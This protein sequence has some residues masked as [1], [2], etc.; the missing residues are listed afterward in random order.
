MSDTKHLPKK[1]YPLCNSGEKK[2]IPIARAAMTALLL[3]LLIAFPVLSAA[4]AAPV[5]SSTPKQLV[6][7]LQDKY[8]LV[9]SLQFDFSQVTRSGGRERQG[10]GYAVFL[11]PKQTGNGQDDDLPAAV[12]RW[13][14]TVPERQVILNDGKELSIYNVRERQL[15]ITPARQLN[16]DITYAFF[17]GTRNILDDFKAAAPDPRFAFSLADSPLRAVRLLPR[18]PDAQVKTVQLWVD[19]DLLIHRLVI[20]DY[21]DSITELTFT[22]IRLNSVD[23][24]DPEQ[25]RRIVDL[26]L[27][28]GTEIITR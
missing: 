22:D 26:Q 10:R 17:A 20:E 25:V 14:Y 27:Q 6:T 9:T 19:D 23:I 11:R 7:M 28:P 4:A 24:N 8:R 5:D 13:N 16:A 15:I 21:F 3:V 1:Q 18:T 2:P 12:I